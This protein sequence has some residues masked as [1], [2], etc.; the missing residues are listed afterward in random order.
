MIR[1]SAIDFLAY[2]IMIRQN[3]NKHIL[4]S[5][6]LFHQYIVDMYAKIETE[7]LQYIRHNQVKL[8]ADNYIHLRD[9][10]NN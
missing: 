7:H 10:L 9:A 8:R 5:R 4:N 3:F 1:V 6:E 2:R